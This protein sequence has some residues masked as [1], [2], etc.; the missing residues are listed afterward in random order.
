MRQSSSV[1]R[2]SQRERARPRISSQLVENPGGARG[3]A[4]GPPVKCSCI[5]W[6]RSSD[7]RGQHG[8]VKP[9]MQREPARATSHSSKAPCVAGRQFVSVQRHNKRRNSSN[10]ERASFD[11]L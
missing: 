5:G 10:I 1:P 9:H 2:S 11:D 3:T 7:N 8:N 6:H 4:Q